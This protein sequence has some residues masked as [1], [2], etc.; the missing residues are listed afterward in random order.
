M[1]IQTG[2]LRFIPDIL[3]DQVSPSAVD[4]RLSNEFTTLHPPP[5]G[6]AIT[7]DPS[8]IEDV[9]ALTKRYGETKR[10]EGEEDF[11]L[12][13][14]QFVLAYT[15]ERIELPNYLAARIEG[16]STLARLGVS[17]HQTA[18]TVH[19]TFRG[20]LRLEIS[21]NGP[22]TVVLRP[23]LRVCQLIIERLGTPSQSTLRSSWQDQRQG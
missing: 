8:R 14:E 3:P 19:A 18:P 21:N 9:E 1:E 12:T 22:Y 15:L 10:L 11:A 23:H 13:P 6:S 4:L 17:I 16:R 20:Q 7:V 2:R 5:K